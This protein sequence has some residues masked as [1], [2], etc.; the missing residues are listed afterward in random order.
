MSIDSTLW[1]AREK[2]PAL[3]NSKEGPAMLRKEEDRFRS[4][5]IPR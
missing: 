5:F 3:E 4:T 2:M 1:A